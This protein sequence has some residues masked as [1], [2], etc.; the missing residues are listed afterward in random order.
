MHGD[1]IDLLDDALPLTPVARGRREDLHLVPVLL[2]LRGEVVRLDLDPAEP[3]EVTVREQG[4]LHG[5][6]PAMRQDGL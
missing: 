1:A 2:E 6:E 5:L 3:R 4:H